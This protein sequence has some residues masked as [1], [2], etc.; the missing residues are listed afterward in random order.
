MTSALVSQVGSEHGVN[1]H[2]WHGVVEEGKG[3]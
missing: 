1:I 2:W 3:G